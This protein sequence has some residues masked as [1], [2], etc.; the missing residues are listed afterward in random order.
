MSNILYYVIKLY[1][2]Y[3]ESQRIHNIQQITDLIKLEN[4]KSIEYS[5][6][7]LRYL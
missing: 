7:N 2:A 3:A 6:Y 4:T 1:E 5:N